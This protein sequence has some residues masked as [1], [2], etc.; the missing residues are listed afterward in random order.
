MDLYIAVC[1]RKVLLDRHLGIDEARELARISALEDLVRAAGHIRKLRQ[2]DAFNLCSIM[3]AKSGRCSENCTFCA[4][5]VHY[6]TDADIYPLV[7]EEEALAR[8]RET[9]GAGVGRFSLVTSGKGIEGKDFTRILNIFRR[10]RRET[11]LSLCASLGII[12][13]EKA[14]SL[15]DAGVDI[16]HHNLETA[17]NFYS[18]VC[19]SH[20]YEDRVQT[21]RNAQEAGLSVCSGG[22]IGLGEEMEHRLEM[23]FQLRELGINS[24]P[25]NILS[26]VKGTPMEKRQILPVEE[27]I[28]TI[29]LF[30]FIMPDAVIRYA[31]GRV[32]MGDDQIRGLAAGI[33]GA[34]VGNYLTTAGG[35]IEDDIAMFKKAGFRIPAASSYNSV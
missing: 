21:I 18:S 16:Y 35:R 17:K 20:D 23:A 14:E 3:N 9:Q 33:N 27:I 11:G 5:S 15:K 28:R 34:I 8:A 13:R 30:R 29:A 4:Q 2:G 32:S 31:G 12:N 24:V 19:T 10:L 7:N 1:M 6:D 26:P 22:I 25:L